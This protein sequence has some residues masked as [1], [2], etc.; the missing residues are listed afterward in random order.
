[1]TDGCDRLEVRGVSLGYDGRPVARDLDLVIPPGRLTVLLGPN[2]S[3]KSTL[4]RAL[5]RLHPVQAG[6]VLLDGTSICDI[7]SKAFARRVGLLAQG[8]TAPEGLRVIDLIRQGRYPHRSVFGRWTPD[9]ESA[10]DT[11]LSLTSL[12]HLQNRPLDTLSGGQRQRAW[13]AMV[14]AQSTPILLLDEPTTYLDLAHQVELM[15]LIRR[16]VDARAMTVVAVLHD[17]N[18]A[19][20]YGDTLVML[21]DGQIAAQGSVQQVLTPTLIARVF[22]VEVKLFHDPDTGLPFCIPHQNVADHGDA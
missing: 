13:I 22:G 20:R 17:L 16:L 14:L 3:G 9:D 18:Q 12:A 6:T 1:M 19:A 5:A 8:A 15:S 10:V 11:A 7:G 2:G 21:K 4:L